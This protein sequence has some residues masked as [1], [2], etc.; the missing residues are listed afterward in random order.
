MAEDLFWNRYEILVARPDPG[1]K[2]TICCDEFGFYLLLND[3]PV[4]DRAH[5]W[6]DANAAREWAT[7]HYKERKE[8]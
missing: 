1:T 6:L 4:G 2:Y 8:K 5:R 3:T 7:I